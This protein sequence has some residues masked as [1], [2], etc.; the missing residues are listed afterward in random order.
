[1]LS[2]VPPM[3]KKWWLITAA[4]VAGCIGLL[5]GIAALFPPPPAVTKENFDRIEVGMTRA[6]V[7]AIFGKP[8]TPDAWDG[9]RSW[10]W[11]NEVNEEAAID[12]AHDKVAQKRWDG[13][14]ENRPIV[15]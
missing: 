7:E 6:Q 8:G 4:I 5:V 2:G 13:F 15:D 3:K 10:T 1:M 11:E 9:G 12:F 14:P